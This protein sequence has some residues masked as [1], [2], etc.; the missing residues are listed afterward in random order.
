MQRLN[1]RD[2]HFLTDLVDGRRDHHECVMYVNQI[3]AAQSA[4]DP[5][6]AAYRY[7]PNDVFCQ[8]QPFRLSSFLFRDYCAD[9]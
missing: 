5:G 1:D 8:R 4:E 7:R 3:R 9:S 2:P 6:Y